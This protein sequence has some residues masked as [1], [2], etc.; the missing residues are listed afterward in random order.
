MSESERK[1]DILRV[2]K[3]R[4]LENKEYLHFNVDITYIRD[5]ENI[6]L[7]TNYHI[8]HVDNFFFTAD[9]FLKRSD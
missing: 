1:K 8:I 9:L 3:K 5:I 6:L 4:L 2:I 7:E